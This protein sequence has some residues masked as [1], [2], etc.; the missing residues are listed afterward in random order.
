VP[1]CRGEHRG[2]GM[3]P[4]Q[5]ILKE[6]VLRRLV[7]ALAAVV[8]LAPL[9]AIGPASAA[10]S[11][12]A[13]AQV[14]TCT[15]GWPVVIVEGFSASGENPA[16]VGYWFDGANNEIYSETASGDDYCLLTLS[17]SYAFRA[18]GTSDCVVYTPSTGVVSLKACDYGSANQQWV[19]VDI[20]GLHPLS[21]VSAENKCLDEYADEPVFMNTCSASPDNQL[22]D[23]L[24][25]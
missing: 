23:A 16:F 19:G 6:H 25:Q 1:C 17:A 4:A 18:K 2:A 24:E 8:A 21:V 5:W 22:W 3:F 14:E 11:H 10:V 7:Y 13:A 15:G 20:G 9:A 12:P